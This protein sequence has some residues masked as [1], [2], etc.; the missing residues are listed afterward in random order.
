MRTDFCQCIWLYQYLANQLVNQ[1]GKHHQEWNFVTEFYLG[2]EN[3]W[4]SK[5][6]KHL[7]K[8]YHQEN[9]RPASNSIEITANVDLSYDQNEFT[10]LDL[11]DLSSSE[12]S[13]SSESSAEF[14]IWDNFDELNLA[15]NFTR[16]AAEMNQTKEIEQVDPEVSTL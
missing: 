6:F 11:I 7:K 2:R 13:E 15:E 3:W 10:A 14:D 5:E 8:I 16:L 4:F 9:L 12:S 1:T